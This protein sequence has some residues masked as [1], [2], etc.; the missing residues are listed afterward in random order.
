MACDDSVDSTEVNDRNYVKV[1]KN[2][3]TFNTIQIKYKKPS[4]LLEIQDVPKY[5]QFNPY[6]QKGYRRMLSTKASVKSLFYFHNETINV[7]SHDRKLGPEF[8]YSEVKN[9]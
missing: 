3:S 2:H 9:L 1:P 4:Q 7:L 8:G 6:I 5:L